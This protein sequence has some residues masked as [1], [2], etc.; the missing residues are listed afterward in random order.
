MTLTEMAMTAVVTLGT[1]ASVAVAVDIPTL[2]SESESTAAEA[3]C[4]SVDTAILA[5]YAEHQVLPTTIEQITPYVLG[6]VTAYRIV[7]GAAAGPGC[8]DADWTARPTVGP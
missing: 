1:V 8:T 4:R 5:F 2:S 7:S 6:D 3:T